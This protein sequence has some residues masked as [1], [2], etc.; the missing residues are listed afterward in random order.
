MRSILATVC[1]AALLSF[2]PPAAAQEEDPAVFAFGAGIFDV[3]QDEGYKAVN[4]NFEWRGETVV[5][6][7]KP[8][9]GIGATTDGSF[10]GYA[11]V[12]LD[13]PLG[14]RWVL[15]PNFAPSLYLDGDGKDLGYPLEFRSGIEVAYRFEDQSRLGIALHHLSNASLGD[16]NPGT[17]TL[18]VYYARPLPYFFGH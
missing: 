3:F 17:E 7:L 16:D 14:D 9:V 1:V 18:N 12:A 5:W 8:L 11:G 10:Y 4:F 15:T 2:T 13:I 6:R